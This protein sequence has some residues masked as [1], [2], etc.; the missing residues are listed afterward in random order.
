MLVVVF[1]FSWEPSALPPL[2][3]STSVCSVRE[4]ERE[5][6]RDSVEVSSPGLAGSDGWRGHARV[7][8]EVRER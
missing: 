3:V 8:M 2:G 5:R 1:L 4:R 6:E 7:S